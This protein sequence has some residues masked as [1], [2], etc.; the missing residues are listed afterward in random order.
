[1]RT[2][3]S[4]CAVMVREP[5]V[6]CQVTPIGSKLVDPRV[7]HPGTSTT[8]RPALRSASAIQV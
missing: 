4:I 5:A 7:R 8:F 1:M 6:A 2:R 3:T